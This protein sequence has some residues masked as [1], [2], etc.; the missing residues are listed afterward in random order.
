QVKH[1][2][3]GRPAVKT[4]LPKKTA[5]PIP[6]P[7]S[8]AIPSPSEAVL[9][10]ASSPQ[11][12]TV[13]PSVAPSAPEPAINDSSE[14]SQKTLADSSPYS[15][16]SSSASATD[17]QKTDLR[18]GEIDGATLGRIRT[19]IENSLTYPAIARRLR[20]QGTVVVSFILKTSGLVEKVEIVMSSGSAMLDSKALQ[21]VLALNGE[22]PAL[23][24][25]AFL[26][27]PITFSLTGH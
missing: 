9:P 18:P 8:R 12:S 4:P 23:T 25:T 27:V 26:Q 3:A 17:S 2:Q 1:K 21:T 14:K 10:E 6:A 16:P 7:T 20:L 15:A 24:K 22:Y 19:M 5:K 11:L 13:R